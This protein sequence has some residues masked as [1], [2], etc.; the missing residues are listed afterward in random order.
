MTETPGPAT[1]PTS[2]SKNRKKKWMRRTIVVKSRADA[3]VVRLLYDFR[4]MVRHLVRFGLA[5]DERSPYTLRDANKEWFQRAW[6]HRYASHW[7]HSAASVAA[8]ILKSYR[9]LRKAARKPGAQIPGAPKVKRLMARIDQEL[10]R[11][12][13][14]VLDITVRP[15]HHL[16]LSV[17]A[18]AKHRRWSAY[19]KHR[20]GEV[21]LTDRKILLTFQLPGDGP[22][23]AGAVGVDLNLG[24]AYYA[25][26]DGV[27]E[28]IDLH[29]MERIQ[30]DHQRRR[31]RLQKKLA[32]NSRVQRRELRRMARRERNRVTDIVKKAAKKFVEKVVWDAAAGMPRRV[33]FEDLTGRAEMFGYSPK[34]NKRLSRWPHSQFQREVEA[35]LPFNAVTRVNPRGTSSRCPG[36]GSEVVHPRWRTSR[37]AMCRRN[38]HRDGLA[39]VAILARGRAAMG[40]T[41]PP[42]GLAQLLEACDLAS[43]PQGPPCWSI[44]G[45]ARKAEACA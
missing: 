17:A 20:L 11:L 8:G 36:C 9:E 2:R 25:R 18:G 3:A 45:D 12:K 35:R 33:V 30:G 14:D 34:Y 13:G 43:A 27:V 16:R 21:T 19:A 32:T 40:S 7:L 1:A 39:A 38:Y 44:S 6:R 26:D 41:V 29:E 31:E 10:V 23:A 15:G 37:C 28:G 24:S 5:A 22:L 4:S 42:E